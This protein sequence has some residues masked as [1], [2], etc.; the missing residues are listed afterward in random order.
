MKLRYLLPVLFAWV[1][2]V[3]LDMTVG[4]AYF[5]VAAVKVSGLFLVLGLIVT[6]A[7]VL[8]DEK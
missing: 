1:G 6:L 7:A 3:V 4:E 5:H 2:L 8:G